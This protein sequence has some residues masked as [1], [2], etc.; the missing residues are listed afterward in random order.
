MRGAPGLRTV[1]DRAIGYLHHR[2]EHIAG[3]GRHHHQ[4]IGHVAVEIGQG[5]DGIEQR[6][7]HPH[8][9][10]EP[11]TKHYRLCKDPNAEWRS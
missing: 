6:R 2:I 3:L 11:S 10:A 4:G 7:N 9:M 1:H 8:L 5:Q